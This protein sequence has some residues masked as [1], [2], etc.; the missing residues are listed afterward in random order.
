[1]RGALVALVASLGAVWVLRL[2]LGPWAAAVVVGPVLWLAVV[3]GWALLERKL[4]DP[5]PPMPVRRA[6][7]VIEVEARA[8]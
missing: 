2:I 8:R 6:G 7:P 4:F 5:P 1:M 3:G